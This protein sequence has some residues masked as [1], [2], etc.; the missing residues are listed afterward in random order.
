MKR[1]I[2]LVTI[3]MS[4][5]VH[6]SIACA[7]IKDFAGVKTVAYL[8]VPSRGPL[9]RAG[10]GIVSLFEDDVAKQTYFVR[11]SEI[12]HFFENSENPAATW[13]GLSAY[14]LQEN[15]VNV[16]YRGINYDRVN[17]IATVRDKNR[18]KQEGNSL[19]VWK[20]PGYDPTQQW[21]FTDVICSVTLDP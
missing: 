13:V 7:A 14:I 5:R 4:T 6:A 10:N 15:P 19:R 16:A 12:V 1:L 9:G 18:V 20:G 17:L 21:A 3:L 11:T 8:S 2:F